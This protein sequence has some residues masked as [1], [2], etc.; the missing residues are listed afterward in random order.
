MPP[1]SDAEQEQVAVLEAEAA[2]K[3]A[4][5]EDEESSE[6]ERQQAEA[7]LETLEQA[8]ETITDKPPVLADELRP[9]V[10]AFLV[11]GPDGQPR[12]HQTLYAEPADRPVAAVDET[13]EGPEPGPRVVGLSQRLTDELAIQRRDILAVHV[14]ADPDFALD[15][16]IFLMVDRTPGRGVEHY[17]SSLSARPPQDPV[18]GFKTPEAAAT[19]ARARGQRGARPQLDRDGHGRRALR[20]LP[21]TRSRPARGMA[22]SGGGGIAGK[23]RLPV[24]GPAPAAS[25]IILAV[26]SGSTSRRGG[27]RRQP[28]SLT[29]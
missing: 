12:L 11:L 6:E 8:I 18:V 28:T 9:T 22:R 1:L 25:M 29:R 5:L 10:G 23:P 15:L 3:V 24:P 4:L 7:D 19:L 26:C 20:R 14:A 17:A 16:A 2:T 27:D 21:G 13:V